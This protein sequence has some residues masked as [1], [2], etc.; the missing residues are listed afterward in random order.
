MMMVSHFR[1]VRAD[2]QTSVDKEVRDVVEYRQKKPE[3]SFPFHS[4]DAP[5]RRL[6]AE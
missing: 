5:D 4:S 6:R 3:A 2:V 1:G